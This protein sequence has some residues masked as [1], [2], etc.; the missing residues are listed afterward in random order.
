MTQKFLYIVAHYPPFPVSE[1]GGIWNVVA[2]DDDE[3]FDLIVA[4]DSSNIYEKYYSIL[5]ENIINAEVLPLI[6]GNEDSRVVAEFT[7]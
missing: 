6:S 7:T 2:K 1:Q 5:R 4:E 3:C